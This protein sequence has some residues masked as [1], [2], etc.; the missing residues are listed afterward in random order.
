MEIKQL[1]PETPAQPEYKSI[2]SS[3]PV[4]TQQTPAATTNNGPQYGTVN[5][6]TINNYNGF[7]QQEQPK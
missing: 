2:F 7:P 1:V 6:I 4:W 5:N 3:D